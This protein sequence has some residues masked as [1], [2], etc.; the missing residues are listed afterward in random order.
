MTTKQFNEA[1]SK[2]WIERFNN[3]DSRIFLIVGMKKGGNYTFLSDETQTKQKIAQKLN[4]LSRLVMSN[5]N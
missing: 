2:K 3:D 1:R 5:D 4:E